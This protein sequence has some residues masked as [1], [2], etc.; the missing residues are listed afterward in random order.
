MA[1][2]LPKFLRAPLMSLWGSGGSSGDPHAL[3]DRA[4]MKKN[5]DENEAKEAITSFLDFIGMGRL[6]DD[7]EWIN[8][9]YTD[10]TQGVAECLGK[11]AIS[12]QI[13]PE[14]E[15]TSMPVGSG[16]DDPNVN[17][18]LPPP[19][20]RMKVS[21]NPL[22]VIKELVGPKLCAKICCLL[23]C[24]ICM[25]FTALF[26]AGIMSTLTFIQQMNHE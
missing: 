12:V 25:G 16:R 20:G 4:E 2:V 9:Y 6:P 10:R 8:M 13:V 18:Y 22:M 21:A 7:G 15:F 11:L 3:G 17:P 19:L 24:G 1:K 26:G 23:C 14:H 5:R